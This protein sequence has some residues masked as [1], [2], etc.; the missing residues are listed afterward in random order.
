M[1]GVPNATMDAPSALRSAAD[2]RDDV[3][4]TRREYDDV[5]VVA[6]DFG[7]G[8]GTSLDVVDGT[9]IVVAGDRQFEFEVPEGASEMRTNGGMLVI[10]AEPENGIGRE[11]GTTPDRGG[12]AEGE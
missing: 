7:A 5:T 2:D 8:V 6:V 11:T 12:T 1:Y 10:E 9:A 4:I 3:A